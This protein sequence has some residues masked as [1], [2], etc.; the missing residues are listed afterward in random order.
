[1]RLI[2]VEHIQTFGSIFTVVHFAIIKEEKSW[3]VSLVP[4]N[5]FSKNEMRKMKKF[6]VIG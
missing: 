5:Q 2:Q 6:I 4:F 1:M 3:V